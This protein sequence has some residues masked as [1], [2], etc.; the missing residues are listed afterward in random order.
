MFLKIHDCITEQN[1]QSGSVCTPY[2]GAGDGFERLCCNR[3]VIKEIQF[4]QPYILPPKVMMIALTK[5]DAWNGKN[6]H[7]HVSADYVGRYGAKIR[8]RS[9]DNAVLHEACA[10]WLVFGE[11][12][13]FVYVYNLE[14]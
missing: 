3:D 11:P 6:Q 8:F 4:P 2:C 9:W 13:L 10:S 5:Y 1:C 12:F 14:Q 7:I